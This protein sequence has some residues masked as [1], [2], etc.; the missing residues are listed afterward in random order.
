[1]VIEKFTDSICL[2]FPHE[3]ER[4]IF[5]TGRTDT[6][7]AFI[8]AAVLFLPLFVF[9]KVIRPEGKEERDSVLRHP[10]EADPAGDEGGHGCR[11]R[12]IREERAD[13][14]CLLDLLH[15]DGRAGPGPGR[16]P[17]NSSTDCRDYYGDGGVKWS[18]TLSI[19]FNRFFLKNSL[20]IVTIPLKILMLL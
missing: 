15:H 10:A 3:P 20:R 16:G 2:D 1:M 5:M 8:S 13:E 19:F 14:E 12:G 11:D 6:S 17:G 7:L 18:L 9:L 4:G